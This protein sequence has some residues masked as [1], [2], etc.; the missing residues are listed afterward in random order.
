VSPIDL[1]PGCVGVVPK[2]HMSRE[3]SCFAL[4]TL[5]PNFPC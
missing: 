1:E 4:D 3:S 5:Q 2:V